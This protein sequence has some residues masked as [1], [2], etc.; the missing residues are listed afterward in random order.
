MDQVFLEGLGVSAEVAETILKAHSAAMAEQALQ[1]QVAIAIGQAGGRNH[2][3]ISALLD[4]ET[5]AAAED[6]AA[7]AGIDWTDRQFWCDALQT[8]ADQIDLLCRLLEENQ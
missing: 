2:T 1:H 5:L 7:V 8:V 6:T 3:A 4:M